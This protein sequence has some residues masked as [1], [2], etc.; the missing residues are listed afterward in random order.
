[1]YCVEVRDLQIKKKNIMERLDSEMQVSSLTTILEVP[2][3]TSC[4]M[5]RPGI[6]PGP[7]RLEAS[8]LAKSYSNSV[9]RARDNMLIFILTN[10]L[11][12]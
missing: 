10:F 4:D 12:K 5:S 6:E 8:I 1:M 7:T 9:L 3:L 11:C 2:R